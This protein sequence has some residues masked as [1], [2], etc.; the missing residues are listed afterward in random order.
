VSLHSRE[1]KDGTG[2]HKGGGLGEGGTNSSFVKKGPGTREKLP[3]KRSGKKTELK[4]C[5]W[6]TRKHKQNQGKNTASRGG[7][8]P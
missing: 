1:A 6:G 4:K 7:G 5:R 2:D 3:S 8:K